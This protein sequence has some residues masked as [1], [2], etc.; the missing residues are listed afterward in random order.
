MRFDK[1]VDKRGPDCF[2][3]IR[4]G[5]CRCL[6]NPENNCPF[7]KNKERVLDEDPNYFSNIKG[8]RSMYKSLKR[9]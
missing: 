5:L 1:C 4:G 8:Y 7:F 3:Y 9:R 2:A 6:N